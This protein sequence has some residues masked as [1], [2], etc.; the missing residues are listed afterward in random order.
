M[1][2]TRDG[3]VEAIDDVPDLWPLLREAPGVRERAQTALLGPPARWPTRS[4]RLFARRLRGAV[5]RWS[6]RAD[7]RPR[8]TQRSGR[9]SRALRHRA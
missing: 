5:L 9:Y 1:L 7:A 2:A 4:A 6:A 8:Q 3:V